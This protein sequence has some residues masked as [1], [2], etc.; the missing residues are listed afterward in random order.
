LQNAQTF[1]PVMGIALQQIYA[2]VLRD[3]KEEL[4]IVHLVSI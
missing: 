1:V 2:I 3:G 4:Q